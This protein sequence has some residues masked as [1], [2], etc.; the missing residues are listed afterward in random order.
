MC[1]VKIFQDSLN[2]QQFSQCFYQI[3][4]F[5]YMPELKALIQIPAS[6]IVVLNVSDG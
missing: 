6:Y 3:F 2:I 5:Q 1:Q 4:R